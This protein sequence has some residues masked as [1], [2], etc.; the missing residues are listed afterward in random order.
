[1]VDTYVVTQAVAVRR[2]AAPYRDVASL[3]RLVLEIRDDASKLTREWWTGLWP[4]PQ[5]AS[6]RTDAERHWN[7]HVAGS[8]G[9]HLDPAIPAADLDVLMAAATKVK[10]CVDQHIAHADASAVPTSVTVTAGEV[11]EVIDVF[12][13]L[14]QRY[15]NLL[16]ASSWLF[17][18]PTIQHDW[19]TIFRERWMR[20]GWVER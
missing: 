4:E 14:F 1:M 13:T 2:Q 18:V 9:R 20:S 19:T 6:V 10:G 15:Y 12:G 3:G 7:T 17:R 11:H 5:D 16:T 8:V